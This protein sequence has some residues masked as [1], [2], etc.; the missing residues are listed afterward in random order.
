[1]ILLQI[2][3]GIIPI[4]PFATRNIY[5]FATS[6]MV[7]SSYLLAQEALVFN[8]TNI[9]LYIIFASNF[10]VNVSSASSYRRTFLQHVLFCSGRDHWNNRVGIMTRE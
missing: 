3:T 7:K 10:Y 2:V 4:I 1:M 9:V 6:S 5:Q 8:I